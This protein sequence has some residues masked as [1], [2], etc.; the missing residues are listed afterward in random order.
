MA[1]GVSFTKNNTNISRT[2][3][4]ENAISLSNVARKA[5]THV[6]SLNDRPTQAGVA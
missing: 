5:L 1:K 2:V 6:L 3:S 4:K